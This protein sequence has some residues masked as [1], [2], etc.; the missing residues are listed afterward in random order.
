MEYGNI[1]AQ[2]RDQQTTLRV[3]EHIGIELIRATTTGLATAPVVTGNTVAVVR[4]GRK[5]VVIIGSVH[6]HSEHQLLALVQTHNPLRPLLAFG[7]SRK[8]Q[9]REDGNDRNDHQQL[10]ESEAAVQFWC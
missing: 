6:R 9:R 1:A 8:Q 3:H 2:I 5:K 7:E 4:I 10:D